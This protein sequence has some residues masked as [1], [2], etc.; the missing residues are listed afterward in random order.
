[1]LLFKLRAVLPRVVTAAVVAF[2]LTACT[3]T[4]DWREVRPAGSGALLLMPCKPSLQSRAVPLANKK[5]QMSLWSCD[6]GGQTWALAHADMGEPGK[7]NAALVDLQTA[8]AANIGA[9]DVKPL[10][11]QI[12]GVTPYTA[13]QRVQW[14]GQ[15]PDGRPVRAQLA[16][17][18]RG[19][20][21]FQATMM[22]ETLSAEGAET[23]FAALRPAP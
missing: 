4:L 6:A 7:V 18:A 16:V 11:L 9:V 3:P 15:L 20:V 22:G 10:P 19:S 8:A 14:R 1:M 2:A 12:P 17:F 21:V 5:V 23:F 13:S